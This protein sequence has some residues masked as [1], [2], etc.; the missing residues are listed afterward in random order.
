MRKDYAVFFCNC[1]KKYRADFQAYMLDERGWPGQ[2]YRI[3]VVRRKEDANVIVHFKTTKQLESI[4]GHV[5]DF[6]TEFKGLSLT[7]SSNRNNI[8]I[9]MNLNNWLSPP[10]A[11]EVRDKKD[12]QI[13]G[14]NR[15]ILYR[16]YLVQH[17]FGHAL[18]YGHYEGGYADRG[19]YC[20]PMMQQT[21]GTAVCQANPWISQIKTALS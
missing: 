11:F 5:P 7:D 21:K 16:Q 20:H 2:G 17:E 18:G 12:N 10:A 3:R 13:V 1:G 6:E 4:Y 8:K 14:N 9:Y 15:L 19:T